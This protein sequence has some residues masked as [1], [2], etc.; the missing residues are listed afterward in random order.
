M[1]ILLYRAGPTLSDWI[2]YYF[3]EGIG[4]VTKW[5]VSKISQDYDGLTKLL[6]EKRQEPLSFCPQID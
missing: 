3:L 1:P 4:A 5:G 6:P 2:T